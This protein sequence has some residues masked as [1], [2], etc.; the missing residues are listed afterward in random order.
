MIV[1]VKETKS[2][3]YYILFEEDE[4]GFI[5]KSKNGTFTRRQ[6]CP[7]VWELNGAIYVIN[8]E[9]L[10]SKGMK[11]FNKILKYEM[12]EVFS[13]DIDNNM[14]WKVAEIISKDL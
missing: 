14:D 2:N 12:E 10:I 3:P 6:D 4:D 8:C 11:N 1:S 7:K 13:L 9:S 5:K